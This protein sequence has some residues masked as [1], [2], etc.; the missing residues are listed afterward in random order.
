MF[1]LTPNRVQITPLAYPP[2]AEAPGYDA[3]RH[4]IFGAPPGD[5]STIA[6]TPFR[7]ARAGVGAVAR[8]TGRAR[9]CAR[10]LRRPL[11]SGP[12]N[13][14]ALGRSRLGFRQG[15]LMRGVRRVNLG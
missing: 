12:R 2:W 4:A 5:R 9:A 6:Q 15:G 14:P 3:G 13:R 1:M 11:F 7:F 8:G 10:P